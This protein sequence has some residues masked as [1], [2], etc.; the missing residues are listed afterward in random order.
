[1]A[2]PITFLRRKIQG[3]HG[4]APGTFATDPQEIDNILTEAWQSI[5]KGASK[6]LEDIVE[7]LCIKCNHLLYRSEE[8]KLEPI[9]T[10]AFMDKCM[11]ANNSA[12][13]L[14]GW[15]PIDFKLLPYE[16]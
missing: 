1:M 16:A 11:R 14:D 3:R 7:N 5:Y 13:G 2:A 4:E 10:T 9:D 8:I 15:D 6:P 12:G